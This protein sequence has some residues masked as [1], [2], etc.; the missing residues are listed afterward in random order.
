MRGGVSLCRESESPDSV[1]SG[2]VLCRPDDEEAV[3]ALPLTANTLVPLAAAL[4]AS[5]LVAVASLAPGRTRRI[6]AQADEVTRRRLVRQGGVAPTGRH[7]AG[8][9]RWRAATSTSR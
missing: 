3:M 8:R 1:R 6:P 4:G 5:A 9:A 7:R 2:R